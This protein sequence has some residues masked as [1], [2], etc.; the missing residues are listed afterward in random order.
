MISNINPRVTAIP[1]F[2]CPISVIIEVVSTLVENRIFP[3]TINIAPTSLNALPNATII[4]DWPDDAFKQIKINHRGNTK[5]VCYL[6]S[7][8]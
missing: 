7:D 6:S 5:T 8:H 3:P 1:L 2:P 4:A